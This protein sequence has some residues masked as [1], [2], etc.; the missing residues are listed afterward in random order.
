MKKEEARELLKENFEEIEIKKYFDLDE[1]GEL[2]IFCEDGILY[3]KPKQ[4]FPI[5][6]EDMMRRVEVTKNGEIIIPNLLNTREMYFKDS[7]PLLEKAIKK[8]KE[9]RK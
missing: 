1:I 6:F 3:F 2:K 8:S 5:V 4:K 7:I 9:L